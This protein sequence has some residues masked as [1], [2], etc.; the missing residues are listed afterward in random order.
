MTTILSRT[1]ERGEVDLDRVS[2][3]IATLPLDIVRHEAISGSV[4]L[5]ALLGRLS[6]L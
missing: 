3:R 6:R 2:R 5:L 1:A 4:P